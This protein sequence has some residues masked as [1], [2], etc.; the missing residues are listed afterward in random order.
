VG[1]LIARYDH[2]LLPI[3]DTGILEHSKYGIPRREHGYTVDDAARALIV[4]CDAQP[5][6]HLESAI[7]VL[8]G[9]V[10]HALEPSGR[11]HNRLGYDRRW[12]DLDGPDDTQGRAIWALGVATASAPRPEWRAA[13][14]SALEGAQIPESPHLRPHAY[15]ALGAYALWRRHPEDEKVAAIIESAATRFAQ[16]SQP[17][18][19]PRLGY[20]NGRLPDAMLAIGEVLDQ[21]DPIDRGLEAL[22]WLDEVETRGGHYSFTPVGGWEPGE[23][24]P[25][26]DQ[27]PIEAAAMAGAAERAWNMTADRRWHDAVFRANSWLSGDNDVGVALY[28]P[29]TGGCRDGLTSTGANEN[30]GAE[31]T[32]AGLA[33]LQA[34][35]R[36]STVFPVGAQRPSKERAGRR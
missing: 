25:G 35:H 27:Q 4:L 36:V 12:R 26:F 34:S 13:A 20:A 1:P 17:W 2:L 24:R 15:A 22:A 9:F 10:M 28:D 11:F 21:H 29:A 7:P 18:L 32:I 14:R 5:R 33:V 3:D 16:A 6:P 8:L 23:P 31:S 30:R 19:E